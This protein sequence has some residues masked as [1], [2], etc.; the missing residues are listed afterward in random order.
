QRI[1]QWS[2]AWPAYPSDDLLRELAE[3]GCSILGMHMPSFRHIAGSEP[4]DPDDMRRTVARAHELGMKVLFYC[5]PYLI[6]I[7]DPRHREFRD[8]RTEC[9]NVWNHLPSSQVCLYQPSPQW[10]ADELCLRSEKAFDY[11]YRTVLECWERYGFD[12][13]YIDWAWPAQG[14]CSDERHGHGPGLFNFY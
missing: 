5:Q 4:A 11:I 1:C 2:S 9:L 10:D 6:S 8:S 13:L 7:H 3:Y 14:I 12:G